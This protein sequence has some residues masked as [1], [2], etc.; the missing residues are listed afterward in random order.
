[1]TDKQEILQSILLSGPLQEVNFYQINDSF[2]ELQEDG[3]W[4][5]DTGIELK[6][7]EG[8][9]SASWN[10][11]LES[12]VIDN[13]SVKNIFNQKLLFQLE[14]ENIKNMQKFVGL[15]VVNANF[16]SLEFEYV[17]DYTMRTEK[18][19]RFVELTLDFENNS[20]IQIAFI[21]YILEENQAPRD[22]SFDLST[23]LLISTKQVFEIKT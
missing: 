23:N 21:D 16:K 7:P 20:K 9:V 4:I 19:K 13:D 5:I 12:Y 22:F 1:M 17:V 14:T 11:E 6:F 10:S 2:F 8:I 18:E 15:N 3:F